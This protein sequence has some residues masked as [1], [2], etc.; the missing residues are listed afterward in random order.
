LHY[1]SLVAYQLSRLP[2][3]GLIVLASAQWCFSTPGIQAGLWR[4]AFT[5][6]DNRPWLRARQP[7][8]FMERPLEG[9]ALELSG[10]WAWWSRALMICPNGHQEPCAPHLLGGCGVLYWQ[11]GTALVAQRSTALMLAPSLAC[12]CPKW[13]VSCIKS[14]LL[15]GSKS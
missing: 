7:V 3:R 14:V 12:L 8:L 6:V 11:T 2:L 5:G 9:Q 10:G 1:S 13:H 15:C 4:G